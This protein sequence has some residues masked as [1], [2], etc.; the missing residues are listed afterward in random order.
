MNE[1]SELAITRKSILLRC[2]YTVVYLIAFE[3]ITTIIQ[4]T[5]LFQYLYLF[6]AKR[7][8]NPVRNFSNRISSYGYQMLRYISLNDNL[9]PF[10]F[11]EFPPEMEVPVEKVKFE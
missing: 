7:Y 10:P 11:G 6:I 4:V 1:T 8:S 5:V 2:L 9:R 3:I